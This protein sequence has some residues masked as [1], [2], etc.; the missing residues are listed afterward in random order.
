MGEVIRSIE[1]TIAEKF[2]QSTVELVGSRLGL[3]AHNCTGRK[4]ISRIEVV[5]D[6]AKFLGRICI[7]KGR[8]KQGE[9]VHIGYAIQQVPGAPLALAAGRCSGFCWK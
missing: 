6:D 5:G 7:R 9:G 4:A 8:G 1:V 2:K 3:D